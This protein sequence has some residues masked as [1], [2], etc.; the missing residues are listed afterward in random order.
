MPMSRANKFLFRIITIILI[1]V[2]I[3]I[4]LYLVQLF[5][6]P[7]DVY[8]AQINNWIVTTN[9]TISR[10]L[11]SGISGGLVNTDP[12]GLYPSDLYAGR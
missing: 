5:F 2:L 8:L 3:G 1:L 6:H 10:E 7:F 4:V 11:I 12:A 9:Q